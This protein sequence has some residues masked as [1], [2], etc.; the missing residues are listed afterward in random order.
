MFHIKRKL[1]IIII[2]VMLCVFIGSTNV[3][4]YETFLTPGSGGTITDVGTVVDGG[5]VS[6][7]NCNSVGAIQYRANSDCG[8]SQRTCCANKLWSGWDKECTCQ[9]DGEECDRWQIYASFDAEN[10]KCVCPEGAIEVNGVCEC[11]E[12]NGY[13]LGDHECVKDDT[14]SCPADECWNGSACEAK[15]STSMSCVGSVQLTTSGTLTRTAI[16]HEGSGWSYG[17]WKGTCRCPNGYT[18]VGS[19]LSGYCD[20]EESWVWSCD[21]GSIVSTDGCKIY[22]G[23]NP[24]RGY[25]CSS[26]GATATAYEDIGAGQCEKAYCVCGG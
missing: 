20:K 15:G 12:A 4:A 23:E 17:G 5:M 10:C 3:K 25:P 21:H 19:G 6:T 13:K 11:D 26:K 16:C 7:V 8:T 18:W 22:G 9:K 14:P 24:L 2:T 1:P